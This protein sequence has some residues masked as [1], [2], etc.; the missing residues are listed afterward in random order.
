MIKAL[1]KNCHQWTN[2]VGLETDRCEHCNELLDEHR[3]SYRKVKHKIKEKS[4]SESL[5]FVR[6]EDSE[7]TRKIKRFLVYARV[8]FFILLFLVSAIIFLSHG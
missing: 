4:E 7:K 6:E 2:R 8:I 1:C 5:L 3:I